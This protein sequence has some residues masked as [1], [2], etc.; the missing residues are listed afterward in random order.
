V[1][2]TF[3]ITC[4]L[5][6]WLCANGAVWNVVQAVAWGRMFA[7]YAQTLSVG[8]ALRETFNPAKPC[9]ICVAVKAARTA[10]CERAPTAPAPQSA[11][12]DLAIELP[13]VFVFSMPQVSWPQVREPAVLARTDS[14]PVPPP[15]V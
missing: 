6:G 10:D 9:E 7:T 2:R 11:K 8:A 15:R 13:S 14:V 4:L 1:R 12:V 3:S 5:F